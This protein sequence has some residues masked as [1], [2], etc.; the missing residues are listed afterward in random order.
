MAHIMIYISTLIGVF[1]HRAECHHCLHYF[2]L[3]YL[4]CKKLHE[5][6]LQRIL[7]NLSKSFVTFIIV[8]FGNLGPIQ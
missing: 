7:L 5:Y 3:P 4:V 6:P 8:I 1:F 2:N